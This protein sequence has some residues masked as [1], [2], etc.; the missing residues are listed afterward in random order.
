MKSKNNS[1]TTLFDFDSKEDK[2]KHDAEVLM[3]KFLSVVEKKMEQNQIT[4]KELARRIQTSP[5]FVTQLFRG[6]KLINLTTLAKIQDALDFEFDILCKE[7][8]RS[9]IS[10]E[11]VRR[12]L[13]KL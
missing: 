6:S 8:K 7:N 4:R 1:F 3:F 12:V 13:E 2:Y 5:S 10:K 11:K 9:K